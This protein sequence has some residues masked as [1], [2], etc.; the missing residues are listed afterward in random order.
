MT[1]SSPPQFGQCSRSRSNTRLSSRT[2]PSRTARWCAQFASHAGGWR[3]LRGRLGLWRHHHRAQLGV[4]R[5]YAMLAK[6]GSA[7]FAQRSYADTKADQVQPP[8]PDTNS[9]VDCSCLARGRATGPTRPARGRG[10]SA[11]SRCM[12]SSGDIIKCVVPSHPRRPR[13]RR[14]RSLRRLRRE[15]GKL[16]DPQVACGHRRLMAGHC[17]DILILRVRVARSRHEPGF[18]AARRRGDPGLRQACAA[19]SAVLPARNWRAWAL[20]RRT[21]ARRLSP[22]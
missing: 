1:C 3:S 17:P 11:A 18:I 4:G 20:A 12:N 7:H 15:D 10:T 8:S 22:P 14:R 5:Q 2:Q 16:R 9:P 6:R 21:A 13:P 19:V